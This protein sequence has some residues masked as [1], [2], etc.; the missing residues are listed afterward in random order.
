[1]L[2][3]L[4]KIDFKDIACNEEILV[5]HIVFPKDTDVAAVSQSLC[6]IQDDLISNITNELVRQLDVANMVR[7]VSTSSVLCHDKYRPLELGVII[8]YCIN[9]TSTMA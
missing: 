5:K 8:N 9:S 2:K 6:A 1:M 3:T 4:G 7:I